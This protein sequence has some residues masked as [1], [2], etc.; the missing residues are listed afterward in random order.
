MNHHRLTL[1]TILATSLS[2]PAAVTIPSVLSSGMVLQRDKP[3]PIWGHAEPKEAVI[4]KFAGIEKL[5]N[6][7]DDGTW[8]IEL[9]AMPAS[10]EARSMTISAGNKI[11]LT[12]ILVGEVWLGSGQSN[13][14]WGVKKCDKGEEETAAA[15]HPQIRL[16]QVPKIS[17]STAEFTVS[18]SWKPCSPDTVADF[19][20]PLYFM[21]RMLHQELNVP[22][23][24]INASWG[25]SRIEP[26]TPLEGLRTVASQRD[27]VR[28][29]EMN[30]PG[31]PEYSQALGGYLAEIENWTKEARDAV[32][33]KAPL[34]PMPM[35]P[36][37]L[38][39]GSQQLIGLYQG[40]IH[41]LKPFALRGITWYQ[42][43]SNVGDGPLYTDRMLALIN[44]W[45]A[46]WQEELPFYFVQLAPYNY[47]KKDPATDRTHPMLPE[48][49][50][51]QLHA[52]QRIPRTGI[53]ITTDIGNFTDIHP[54][55]KQDVG[56]RLALLAMH[57]DYGR[58]GTE[59]SGPTYKAHTAEASKLRI[60]FD[61]AAGLSARDGNALS[62][63]EIAGA[64]QAFKPAT[65]TI[66]AESVTLTHPDV[67]APLHARFAWG[68]F[69]TPNLVNK[70][71]LPAPAFR[72]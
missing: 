60:H 30:T 31:T 65:A 4:V 34:P 49:W 45:R 13:M 21:G 68:Q 67:P 2:A 27:N 19:S 39:H 41:P 12:D 6:A 44:G 43:E 52:S 25:G 24:L 54:K 17:S 8:Q 28:T 55:N 1:A 40:M 18:A 66:E 32:K 57:H 38:A 22:I 61:H 70:A 58:T 53:V 50:E 29:I 59:C 64:D 33:K 26:W 51:A 11:E 46:V 9:P 47:S 16:F 71:N 62:W 42:G 37:P 69:A 48:F 56:R 63:F 20:G 36:G 3:V 10:T 15:H 35:E 23:G 14:E 72:F 7:K 5:T